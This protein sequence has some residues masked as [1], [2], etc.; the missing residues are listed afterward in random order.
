MAIEKS[1]SVPPQYAYPIRLGIVSAMVLIFS[2]NCLKQRPSQPLAA[3]GMG[4]AVFA[5]WIGPDLISDYRQ[6]FLFNN[7]VTGRA[8]SSIPI[9]LRRQIWF[10]LIRTCSLTVLVPIIEELFWR[11]WMMRWL[12]DHRFWTVP[13]GK[14]TPAAFWTVA[15]LFASEHGPYWDVGLIAGVMYNWWMVRTRN[16]GDC[17]LVHA[18][19]N[20][21]LLVYVLQTGR[22]EYLS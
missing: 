2:R 14:Y 7:S 9:E 19:T 20:G 12:I 6:S 4:L 22:W 11:A 8:V 18:V 10:V 16:L 5:I 21:A 15:V 13:L 1:L 17:I 3:I